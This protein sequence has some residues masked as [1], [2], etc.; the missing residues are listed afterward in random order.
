MH[1]RRLKTALSG[2]RFPKSVC[3]GVVDLTKCMLLISAAPLR[4]VTQHESFGLL[5]VRLRGCHTRYRRMA[6]HLKR[7]KE[8]LYASAED[9]TYM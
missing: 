3:F 9:Q 7:P 1:S 8:R 6:A 5:K 4:A 2:G